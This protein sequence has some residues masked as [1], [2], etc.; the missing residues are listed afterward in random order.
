MGFVGY[1]TLTIGQGDQSA[2]TLIP[3]PFANY[4]IV[5]G[6]AGRGQCTATTWG[7]PFRWVNA[8][9][10]AI[11]SSFSLRHPPNLDK[12]SFA[13]YS[14]ATNTRAVIEMAGTG[15]KSSKNKLEHFISSL[16]EATVTRGVVQCCTDRNSEKFDI[17]PLHEHTEN[18]SGHSGHERS[19]A[20]W[21][22]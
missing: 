3:S 4:K 19:H 20:D 17:S 15:A 2:V 12:D 7:G 13:V 8:K 6:F 22:S 16:G 18:C 9:L 11:L 14:L 10:Y 1:W 5:V 21:L